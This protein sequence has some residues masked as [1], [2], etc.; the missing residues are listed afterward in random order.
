M[1][2]CGSHHTSPRKRSEVRT[3][4]QHVKPQLLLFTSVSS[5][6]EEK[7]E[8]FLLILHTR[9]YF[10]KDCQDKTSF[11]FFSYTVEFRKATN[12]NCFKNLVFLCFICCSMQFCSLAI[13]FQFS[14]HRLSKLFCRAVL[15]PSRCWI[16]RD[17][18]V[19]GFNRPS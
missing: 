13:S 9:Q 8:E 7:E 2:I 11:M 17:M 16:T 5:P 18:S 19:L 4:P 3:K 15:H 12:R 14:N 10:L 1:R 6:S